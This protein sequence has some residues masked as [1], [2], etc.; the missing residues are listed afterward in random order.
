MHIEIAKCLVIFS[1]HCDLDLD[2][3]YRTIVSGAYLLYNAYIRNPKFG[4][5]MHLEVPVTLTLTSDLVSR[6][7]FESGA[8]LLYF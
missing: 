3:V 4:I 8:Y 1:G 2:L 6:N 5:W 7:C